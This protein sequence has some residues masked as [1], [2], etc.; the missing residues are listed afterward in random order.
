MA[1]K[2]A[3]SEE[4]RVETLH[5]H[6]RMALNDAYAQLESEKTTQTFNAFTF[7]EALDNQ[8]EAIEGE[9]T[10]I[11]PNE[12]DRVDRIYFNLQNAVEVVKQVPPEQ[13]LTPNEQNDVNTDED[14]RDS[15]DDAVQDSLDR[16]AAQDEQ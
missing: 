8:I 13:F 5:K 14:G 9:S 2:P 15:D 12:L 3:Q 7:E 4:R 6:Q 10:K 11:R 16:K 1:D